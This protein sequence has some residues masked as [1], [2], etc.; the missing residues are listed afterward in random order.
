MSATPPPL[1]VSV[2]LLNPKNDAFVN[3]RTAIPE[4]ENPLPVLTLKLLVTFGTSAFLGYW[5]YKFSAILQMEHPPFVRWPIAA[6]LFLAALIVFVIYSTL[7]PFLRNRRFRRP[8][9]LLFGELIACKAV[10]G[11]ETVD[12]KVSYRFHSPAGRMLE[13]TWTTE[14]GICRVEDRPLP[15]PGVRIAIAYIDDK[16]HRM[17]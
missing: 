7:E 3:A 11:D 1:P 2:F 6:I 9:Q 5:I 15:S 17:L 8:C 16:T 13:G 10:H 4:D 12:W 14:G